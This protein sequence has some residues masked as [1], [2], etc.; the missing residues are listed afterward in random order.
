MP[1]KKLSLQDAKDVAKER[2]GE[3]L[4]KKYVRTTEKLKWKCYYGH[5]WE[6]TMMNVRNSGT[7]CPKCNINIGEE[8]TRNIMNILFDAEFTTQY[9]DWLEGLELDGYNEE[10]NIAFEYDGKQHYHFVR[11]FHRTKKGF[12]DQIERDARKDILCG[13]NGVILI[14][15]PYTLK[16]DEIKEYICDQVR[17]MGLKIPNDVDIDYRS[18]GH[19]YA[20]NALYDKLKENVEAKGWALLSEHY[21]TT[22]DKVMIRCNVGHEFEMEPRVVT[23]EKQCYQCWKDSK[24]GID[25]VSEIVSNHDIE[26]ISEASEYES[27][28]SILRFKC[29]RGH[30][31]E[32][33]SK[34]IYNKHN[35]KESIDCLICNSPKEKLKKIVAKHNG[36]CLDEY[37]SGK[38]KLRFK[39]KYGHVFVTTYNKI[40]GGSWCH[41]CRTGRKSIDD[42]HNLARK[43]GGKCL[44]TKYVN[45]QTNLKWKCSNGHI[46]WKKPVT[47]NGKKVFCKL[48]K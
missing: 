28:Q 16:Y 38:T 40:R 6:S 34:T 37:K 2:M 35:K 7:W 39:C 26:C 11:Y 13:V 44:S 29:N 47:I 25:R 15:V 19:I 33:T 31:F 48:C 1:R 14:R 3:C 9:P 41:A 20:S 32:Y 45:N 18:F 42:M 43:Y 36:E 10:L 22:I 27:R 5:E 21:V 24:G 4:S 23:P 46:F 8:I 30:E 17:G 12:E